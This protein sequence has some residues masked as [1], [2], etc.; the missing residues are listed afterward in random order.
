[1][2]ASLRGTVAGL[3]G[4]AGKDRKASPMPEK[5]ATARLHP[6]PNIGVEADFG[7]P[8][9]YDYFHGDVS[10]ACCVGHP[11]CSEFS[12]WQQGPQLALSI[13][14]SWECAGGP[15]FREFQCKVFLFAVACAPKLDNMHGFRIFV[16]YFS[17]MI[18]AAHIAAVH[19]VKKASAFL[20]VKPMA[21]SVKPSRVMS[22]AR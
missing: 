6:D 22:K 15:R 13:F 4:I 5:A 7:G 9:T 10:F 14:S 16:S 21:R 1:M 8:G 18:E 17:G 2:G 19:F 11:Q 12:I 3:G 20:P